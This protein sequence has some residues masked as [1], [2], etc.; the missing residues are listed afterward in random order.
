V[1]WAILDGLD[2]DHRREVLRIAV[3]R[4]FRSGDTIF[5]QG[6]PGAGVH[7][8]DVGHVAIRAV[9]P[10][11][12]TLT[13]DITPPGGWFGE[14][15]L[16]GEGAERS[17]SAV[18]MG[19]V[20]TMMIGR[21]AFRDLQRQNPSVTSVLVQLLADRVRR[22]TDQLMDSHT[23]TAEDRVLK[24]LHRLASSFGDAEPNSPADSTVTVPITQ[25]EL[26]SLAG[27]TRPTANRALQ[28]LVEAGVVSL[29][30]GRIDIHDFRSL[31]S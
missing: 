8:V 13:L 7:L 16:L 26:A 24:Q 3:R 11:G 2:D 22:L 18:A 29:G 31:R 19:R 14:L 12:N 6:D 9:D 21:D 4:R 28:P 15:S 23:R 25:E 5:H 10:R 1:H 30:R 17:A 20:E 27:T